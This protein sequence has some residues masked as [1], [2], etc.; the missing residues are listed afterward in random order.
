MDGGFCLDYVCLGSDFKELMGC[1]P[2]RSVIIQEAFINAVMTML[3]EQDPV[4][5]KKAFKINHPG[6]NIGKILKDIT[7]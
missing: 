7:V 1:V 3:N 2:S 4:T 5:T 6:G